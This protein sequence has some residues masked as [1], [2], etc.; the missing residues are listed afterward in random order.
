MESVTLLDILIIF[1]Y[2]IGMLWIGFY[3]TKKIK[4]S[5][6]FF[7]A[8][9]TLGPV[10][11]MATVCASIIGGSALIGRGGY[12][13]SGGM[14]A[15]AI[16]LPYMIGM[17]IFSFCT[18]HIADIGRKYNITSIPELMEYRFG[19]TA[20]LLAGA[21]IAYS[22]AATVG[23]QIS[24]T[25]TVFGVVG[26]N[27][28][29]NYV[30]GAVIA[31]A[32]FVIY[33]ASSGLFGVVYTD[34]VQFFILILFVYILL[35]IMSVKEVGGHGGPHRPDTARKVTLEPFAGYHYV[36]LHQPGH[37]HCRRRILATGLCGKRPEIRLAR[38]IWRYAGLFP[39]HCRYAVFRPIR[40]PALPELDPGIR[41][42]GLC[43]PGNGSHHFAPGADWPYLCRPAFRDDVLGGYLYFGG[44]AGGRQ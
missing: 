5:G 21:M 31:S 36:D 20:K 37:D 23:A 41:Y 2:L 7:I 16:A 17:Y 27:F 34:L 42:G 1:A 3:F 38:T 33:T 32:I 22:M 43:Y 4:T 13:Y 19:K 8:G 39:H 12:A 28:G 6:D 14:V 44:D 35:P 40:G 26:G 11:L 18:G 24:A 9:R 30:W 15:I 10:V 25:A 29:I